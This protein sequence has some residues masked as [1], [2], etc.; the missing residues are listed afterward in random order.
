M[1]GE[2]SP[3]LLLIHELVH[4]AAG[5]VPQYC[6]HLY[7]AYWVDYIDSG[8]YDTAC[9]YINRAYAMYGMEFARLT[10]DLTLKEDLKEIVQQALCECNEAHDVY[11]G[12]AHEIM[13]AL[14]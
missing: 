3:S 11:Q 1:E 13:E 6:Q 10:A 5:E 2:Q 9:T 14:Q 12:A 4:A 7:Y 8:R